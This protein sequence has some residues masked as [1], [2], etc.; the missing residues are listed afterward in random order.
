MKTFYFDNFQSSFILLLTIITFHKSSSNFCI[1]VFGVYGSFTIDIGDLSECIYLPTFGNLTI[2]EKY[3]SE[4]GSKI[5]N[6]TKKEFNWFYVS[7]DQNCSEKLLVLTYEEMKNSS[8]EIDIVISQPF[9]F[10]TVERYKINFMGEY[11]KGSYEVFGYYQNTRL[12]FKLDNRI[13]SQPNYRLKSKYI[14]NEN[15]ESHLSAP[16]QNSSHQE[17]CFIGNGGFNKIVVLKD[18]LDLSKK[19][20]RAITFKHEYTLTSNKKRLKSIRLNTFDATKCQ[21]NHYKNMPS[22]LSPIR[23]DSSITRVIHSIKLTT[24]YISTT[25]FHMN[26]KKHYSKM[27]NMLLFLLDCQ[28]I[29]VE[30]AEFRQLSH[31]FA[32]YEF[33]HMKDTE[34]WFKKRLI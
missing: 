2:T 9:G 24:V 17:I 32:V 23:Y 1:H 20:I 33:P 7:P 4:I 26:T 3:I 22:P 6:E 30:S 5:T 31:P 25:L 14:A 12:R 19:V 28:F 27:A 13:K 15:F 18:H 8:K 11:K 16:F 29:E 21:P 34:Y 10:K